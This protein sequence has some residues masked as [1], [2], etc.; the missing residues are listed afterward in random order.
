MG[1]KGKQFNNGEASKTT[2][3]EIKKKREYGERGKS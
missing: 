2:N 3:L 1:G